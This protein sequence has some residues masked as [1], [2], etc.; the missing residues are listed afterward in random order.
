MHHNKKIIVVDDDQDIHDLVDQSF[1]KT[2]FE[3]THAYGVEEAINL[4]KNDQFTYGLFDIILSSTASSQ[5]IIEFLETEDAGPNK[6]LPICVMSSHMDEKFSHNVK[7]KGANVIAT[8]HK[9]YKPNEVRQVF[10]GDSEQSILLLED[11]ADLARLIKKELESNYYSVYSVRTNEKAMELLSASR[12]LC[13]IVDNNLGADK[14]SKELFDFLKSDGRDFD[15]PIILTGTTIKQEIANDPKLFVFDMIEKPFKK[16]SFSKSVNQLLS[17]SVN[18]SKNNFDQTALGDKAPKVNP[19]DLDEDSQMDIIKGIQSGD[20][21][22]IVI[23]GQELINEN[24]QWKV[25]NLGDASDDEGP[26]YSKA[27]LANQRNE[28][29]LTPAMLAVKKGDISYLKNLIDDGANLGLRTKDGKSVLHFAAQS[30]EPGIVPFLVE[31]GLKV[32]ERDQKNCEPLYYAICAQ[33]KP[34]VEAL[35][36]AGARMNARVEGKTYLTVAVLTGNLE[37]TELIADQNVSPSLKDHQGKS[38]LDYARL[39]GLKEIYQ[40]LQSRV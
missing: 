15:L 19:Y 8:L 32:N 1:K 9:P 4:I 2:D 40:L 37:L 12:F 39:K 28:D 30:K 5:A 27:T 7:L 29:G 22:Y 10:Q 20:D 38:S 25:K 3:L 16:S 26:S 23:S 33:N 34:I 13:A 21:D 35:I 6:H 36:E 31:Q 17:W 18:A 24:E 14:S 11:D